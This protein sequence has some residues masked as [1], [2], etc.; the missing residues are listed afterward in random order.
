MTLILV[1]NDDVEKE[2]LF[3]S[4]LYVTG[5]INTDV[6]L[7]I[8]SEYNKNINYKMDDEELNTFAKSRIRVIESSNLTDTIEIYTIN[9]YEDIV[10]T[11]VITINGNKIT[12]LSDL[13]PLSMYA[14]LTF[15]P[16]AQIDSNFI[17]GT[18]Y[19]IYE[20]HIPEG[21]SYSFE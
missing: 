5:S 9:L 20:I 12:I 10:E 16:Y 8:H 6:D 15:L 17:Q 7:I 11:A 4:T 14:S 21:L 2:Q 1:F 18:P 19:I 13:G 3:E